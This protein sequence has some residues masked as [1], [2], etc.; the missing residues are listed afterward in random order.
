MYYVVRHMGPNPPSSAHDP[1][2][3]LHTR[4]ET[5]FSVSYA[6]DGA[7]LTSPPF[8]TMVSVLNPGIHQSVFA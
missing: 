4:A 3:T 6:S 8:A 5:F 1:D 7:G 2:P